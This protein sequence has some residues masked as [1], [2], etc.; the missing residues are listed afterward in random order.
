MSSILKVDTIQDQSGN[1]I[2]NESGNV[3]TIGASG[4][5][6]TVPAGATVSGFTSAGI[7]DNAT[8][9][10]ITIS[11]D[12]D[13]TFTEDI[14]LGDSKKAIFGAG[15]DFEILHNSVTGN[16]FNLAANPLEIHQA[17]TNSVLQLYRD[18]GNG[19][20]AQFF[21]S[22]TE[23]GSIA[24]DTSLL[25]INAVSALSFST[26]NGSERMSI[27]SAGK[28]SIGTSTPEGMLRITNAG[29]TSETLLTLEDT[30]GSGAHSQITL[31]NTTGTVASLLT[32]SDNL[33]FRVD[34]ATVFANISGTEHMRI[35]S[36]GLVGIGTSAPEVALSVVGLDTQIH[37][38][39][40]PDSGGYLMSEAAG[41]FGISGGAG[42]KVGGTGWRAKS[43][44]AAIIRHDSGGDIKFFSDTS[45][46]VGNSFT[47]TERMRLHSNGVISSTGGI[48][49]GVGIANTASNVLDDYEEG[50]WTP[51]ASNSGSWSGFSATNM[52]VFMA[53]YTKVGRKVTIMAGITFPDSG[54]S[55]V[56]TGDHIQLSGIPFSIGGSG[57]DNVFGAIPPQQFIRDGTNGAIAHSNI[58]YQDIIQFRVVATHGSGAR[59]QSGLRLSCTYFAD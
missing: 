36:S 15:S 12:E 49:L 23:V 38:S 54:S 26:N 14:L 24:T 45:L 1:N 10:A 8:S 22:T 35:K 25:K 11:S 16:L 28:I 55:A 59:F 47:P 42:F 58:S 53:Q 56:A 34:D 7:D 33:E 41:Q 21:G 51:V 37:F 2:I 52:N 6:I 13:V 18:P 9:T 4:D 19:V 50:V 43:T 32:T 27:S 29:Q 20:I 39:E 30:G 5:T 48:A 44:E 31:K 40:A 57:T 17:G 46:T 3:I